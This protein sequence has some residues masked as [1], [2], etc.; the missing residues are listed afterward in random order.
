MILQWIQKVNPAGKPTLITLF[1]CLLYVLIILFNSDN[2]PLIF[3][4]YDGYFSYYIAEDP[5]GSAER[6][7]LAPYRYQRIVY[8]ILAYA[9][10]FGQSSWVPWTLVFINLVAIGLGTWWT[11]KLLDHLDTSRW[12]AL[13][14]GLYGGQLLSL[15]TDLVEPLSLA[16]VQLA[17][18]SWMQ[19]KRGWSVVWFAVAVLTKE[20]AVLFMVAFFLYTLTR[21][22]WKWAIYLMAGGIP[23]VIWQG[24]LW[25]W[26]GEPGFSAGPA[27]YFVPLGGLIEAARI[28]FL[29]FLLIAIIIVP[30][31]ILPTFAGIFLSLRSLRQKLYHPY[32][33]ALL[34]N[35]TLMLFLPFATMRESSAMVRLTQGVMVGMLLYGGLVKSGRVLNYSVLWIFTNVLLI[36][37]TAG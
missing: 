1:I 31:S 28:S 18:F 6:L 29:G 20:T 37:G 9:L 30:M 5:L 32:V 4:D 3:V 33:F 21:R 27:F 34:L 11:E 13:V 15:R 19:N 12:Y 22:E 10:A 16:L 26:L 24:V 8:P 17:I 35:C 2:D 23:Y 36:K 7:D 25:A 14:F